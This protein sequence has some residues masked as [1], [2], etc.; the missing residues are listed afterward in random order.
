MRVL[1]FIVASILIWGCSTPNEEQSSDKS[2]T[3]AIADSLKA[4]EESKMKSRT[5]PVQ[6]REPEIEMV[7][8]DWVAVEDSSKALYKAWIQ[9]KDAK[10]YLTTGVKGD[11]L[12][13]ELTGGH[14][15]IQLI[16]ISPD[17][18]E[19]FRQTLDDTPIKWTTTYPETG[20]YTLIV[21]LDSGFEGKEQ[22]KTYFE[23]KMRLY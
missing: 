23:I 4:V 12:S 19:V 13:L 9:D 2:T 20:R 21:Q 3:T 14:P 18:K 1:L 6:D 17:E 11:E 15:A 22:I 10:Y 8:I 5:E 7:N 16:I